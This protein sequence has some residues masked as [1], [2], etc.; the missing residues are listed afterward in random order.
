[1]YRRTKKMETQIKLS[2][3]KRKSILPKYS[4]ITKGINILFKVA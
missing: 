3:I 1:M 2:I 4:K